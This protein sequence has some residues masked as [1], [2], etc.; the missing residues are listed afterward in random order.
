MSKNDVITTINEAEYLNKGSDDV[1]IVIE[2]SKNIN[3]DVPDNEIDESF[4]DDSYSFCDEGNDNEPGTDEIESALEDALKFEPKKS[5]LPKKEEKNPYAF[6]RHHR[7]AEMITEMYKLPKEW[8]L[9]PVGGFR[10][11]KAAFVKDWQKEGVDRELIEQYISTGVT[12]ESIKN[13][14]KFYDRFGNGIGLLT[15]EIS[16]G[17]LA[18]DLDGQGALD[19]MLESEL[20]VGEPRPET[21]AWTSGKPGRRQELYQVPPETRKAIKHLTNT[22]IKGDDWELD[23]RYNSCQSVMPMSYHPETGSYK[24]INSP[25]DTE[26]A[27]LPGWLCEK[28]INK[29]HIDILE[30]KISEPPK[31][32][33]K[34]GESK[35]FDKGELIPWLN[36]QIANSDPYK[37]FNSPNHEWKNKK[38]LTLWFTEFPEYSCALYQPPSGIWSGIWILQDFALEGNQSISAVDYEWSVNMNSLS[39]PEK[40]KGKN[41]IAAVKSLAERMGWGHIPDKYSPERYREAIV[42]EQKELAGL[43]IDKFDKVIT[44]TGRYIDIDKV[45]SEL[46]NSGYIL[47]SNVPMGAGKTTLVKELYKNKDIRVTAITPTISLGKSLTDINSLGVTMRDEIVSDENK[48]YVGGLLEQETRLGICYPSLWQIS[49]RSGDVFLADE[50]FGGLE[51]E[52]LAEVFS[53]EEGKTRC[54]CNNALIKLL[55]QHDKIVLF[56]AFLNNVVID[57]VKKVRPDLEFILV[58][59]EVKQNDREVYLVSEN[60]IEKKINDELSNEKKIAIACDSIDRVKALEAKFVNSGKT[61][62]ALHKDNAANKE[63]Q[64]LLTNPTKYLSE[65]EHDIFIYSPT[66]GAGASVDAVVHYDFVFGI[67]THLAASNF[68]QMLKRVRKEVPLYYCVLS[69]GSIEGCQSPLWETQKHWLLN[70][71]NG[72][73]L[74]QQ[75]EAEAKKLATELGVNVVD[76]MP[77]VW[78]SVLENEDSDLVID[79]TAKLRAISAYESCDRVEKIHDRLRSQGYSITVIVNEEKASEKEI[80]NYV[81]LGYRVSGL[82]VDSF[83]KDAKEETKS[84]KEKNR[85]IEAKHVTSCELITEE[86][87]KQLDKKNNP[88][89]DEKLKITRYRLEKTIPQFNKFIEAATSEDQREIAVIESYKAIFL[90]D[91]RYWLR[92]VSN[93][94]KL[95]NLEK[96]ISI[97]YRDINKLLRVWEASGNVTAQDAAYLKSAAYRF[98]IED[99]KFLDLLDISG[100]KIYLSTY[101]KNI[102]ETFCDSKSKIQ[103]FSQYFNLTPL[104]MAKNTSHVKWLNK[105]LDRFS[106][107]LVNKKTINGERY[108]GIEK[109]QLINVTGFREFIEK[110]ELDKLNE[111]FDGNKMESSSVS[112]KASEYIEEYKHHVIEA[113]TP[114]SPEVKELTQEIVNSDDV[115]VIEKWS[116]LKVTEKYDLFQLLRDKCSSAI[117]DLCKHLKMNPIQISCQLMDEIL[118][119]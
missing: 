37:L 94:I 110:I 89:S 16:G 77:V 75:V 6:K 114:A 80:A 55:Q 85:L 40:P 73:I 66:F 50:A 49:D 2:F 101:I 72:N 58:N 20:A 42:K 107:K 100:E 4:L 36:Y 47:C 9:T 13:K 44:S 68:C 95:T 26:I 118:G 56:D 78:N 92:G 33:V 67:N 21:L 64:E 60:F 38:G 103:K 74:V 24:W 12:T 87:F 86:Q 84:Y 65:V 11:A 81:K 61:V 69:G 57:F 104:K 98:L 90:D 29:Y 14:G 71:V 10:D 91:R 39:V 41:F 1:S 70:S 93:F 112:D 111:R 88:S 18:I 76:T 105:L 54:A 99:V 82:D 106:L 53:A 7:Y 117:D 8:A 34:P 3:A 102:C 48:D 28:I 62:I 109:T 27:V 46:P 59:T 5:F 63:N 30:R 83:N 116:I 23:F 25:E 15:G 108:Y 19:L 31:P 97:E 43:D 32:R 115:N 52:M 79:A 35:G 113:Y 96:Q 17:I 119:I 45:K 22:K 51:F